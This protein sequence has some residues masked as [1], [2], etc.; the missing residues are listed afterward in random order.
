MPA[1]VLP[2]LIT[3]GG[4]VAGGLVG[5]GGA[6]NA[7]PVLPRDLQ[8]QRSNN[9]QLLNYLLGFGNGQGGGG[10]SP[11]GGNGAG[12]SFAGG[13]L[14]QGNLGGAFG[15]GAGGMGGQR[16]GGGVGGQ[17]PAFDPSAQGAGMLQRLQSY[18]G[19]LGTPQSALQGQTGDAISKLLSGPSAYD[20]AS[21]A[22]QAIL[23]GKPG[24]GVM[25]ALQ[26]Q[27]DRN[28]A[29]ANQTGGRF[30][31]ANAVLK[32]RA[33]DDY[34]LLGAQAAQQG[35]QTQL[36]A[37]NLL[38]LLQGQNL[39]QQQAGYGIGT[40]QAQQNAS[41]QQQAL[42]ILMQLLGQSQGA[43]LGTQNQVSPTGLQQG[44]GVG[45]QLAQLLAQF[46]GG[47]SNSQQQLVNNMGGI[48]V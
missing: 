37:G 42:Q 35:Q 38:G 4:A 41:G 44:L 19:Q 20:Q 29:L 17:A 33:L 25:D 1:A 28:L 5:G 12:G 23:N 30:G 39:Q 43:T 11:F 48:G 32:S 27:F 46:G 45:G 22:L 8:G 10:A 40:Q 7:Q 24:Q 13:A 16:G 18:F 15:A 6:S 47:G 34:N 21:P 26:P 36:Q 14:G 3:A 2:A 31:T 9:I